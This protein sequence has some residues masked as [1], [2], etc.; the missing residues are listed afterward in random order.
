MSTFLAALVAFLLAFAALAVGLFFRRPPLK[1][2]CGNP[3]EC[4]CAAD[5]RRPEDFC[6]KDSDPSTDRCR[7]M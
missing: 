7:R 1:R 4:D 2:N 6:A 3:V 5:G